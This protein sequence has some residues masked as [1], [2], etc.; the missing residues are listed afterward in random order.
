M[1][2]PVM[3]KSKHILVSLLIIFAPF[4][5]AS[6][7]SSIIKRLPGFDGDLP[8]S[9]ETGYIGVGKD[10]AVQIFYYF[11]ESERNPSEDPF[12]LYLTGGPG[13]S[14]LYSMMYQI[15]PLNF[16]LE[17]STDDNITLTLNPYPWN[18]VANMLFIDAPAGAGFSYATTY[19][20]SISSDSLLASYAYDFLRKWFTDHPSFL[21]NPFYVSGI[22]Y[23]GIIIPNVALHVYNGNERGNQPQLNIKGVISVSPLTDKF[24]DF[25]SRFEFAHR[26][27]LISDNIYESTTQT[28]KGNYVINDLHNILCANNLQWVNE[29]TSRI[30]LENI[31]DPLCDTTYQ[32]P[33]C[34]EARYLLIGIWANQKDVQRALN[35]REGTIEKWVIKNESLHYDLGKKDTTCYSYDVFSTIPIHKKLLAKK[36]QYLI[37]CGDHDMTFPHVGTE[38]WIRS[39]NLPVEKRWAPW[40]VNNQIAGYQMTYAL[41]EYTLKYATIKGAGHGVAL[42]KPEEALT[43][44]DGWLASQNYL[45]DS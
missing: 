12:L 1:K 6:N 29:C 36:C 32:D 30:N 43:M 41:S 10:E 34:R 26:L 18:K 4:I 11:V 31:L 9:L 8:F 39:L 42:Y 27:S 45:S 16:N 5:R 25:N 37:I 44:V 33:T 24:S 17:T 38:R 15:G 35:V 7:S 28:C 14:V 21:S 19:E 20:A 40:F 23:M 2:T 13:T 22:S 3:E